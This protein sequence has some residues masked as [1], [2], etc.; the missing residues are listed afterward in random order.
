MAS[1]LLGFD[2]R[3][4]LS[5]DPRQ[6]SCAITHCTGH[7]FFFMPLGL[8]EWL[9]AVVAARRSDFQVRLSEPITMRNG[10]IFLRRVMIYPRPSFFFR[11][12][13]G[14]VNLLALFY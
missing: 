6:R 9:F 2:P 14:L 8:W 1:V 12:L 4:W 5:I 13:W 3:Y 10:F 11:L 7:V